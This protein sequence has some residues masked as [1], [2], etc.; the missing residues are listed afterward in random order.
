MSWAQQDI[1]TALNQKGFNAGP[2]DGL[3]GPRTKSAISSAQRALKQTV[4]GLPTQALLIAIN[5]MSFSDG[6]VIAR[7][8]A[9]FKGNKRFVLQFFD[10]PNVR[11]G[12]LIFMKSATATAR[13]DKIDG[14]FAIA[15]L[16][17]G[18]TRLISVGTEIRK[19][20]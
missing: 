11:V 15:E 19:S 12:E 8:S 5:S 2:A 17:E 13:V 6:K 1:Q 4:N 10:T 20:N 3:I 7:I 16:I 9:I 14:E 18:D